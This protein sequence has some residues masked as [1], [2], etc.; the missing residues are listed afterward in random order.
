VIAVSHGQLKQDVI[1]TSYRLI[2][3]SER[4]E[5]SGEAVAHELDVDPNDSGI[6]H[7]FFAARD[8]GYLRCD[9]PGGMRLPYRIRR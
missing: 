6:Y 4:G 9:F 1:A 5:T 8:E 3:E 2:D 7:A